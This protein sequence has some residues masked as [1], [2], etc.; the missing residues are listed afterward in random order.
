LLR[1]LVDNLG[2]LSMEIGNLVV[3]SPWR[4]KNQLSWWFFS[5][6]FV[7]MTGG[8]GGREFRHFQQ[9]QENWW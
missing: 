6:R 9:E 8:C 1:V 4:L 7:K 3:D 5:R 2:I